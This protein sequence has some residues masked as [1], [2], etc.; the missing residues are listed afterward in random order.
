[1]RRQRAILLLSL[2][3]AG[4]CTAYST[5]NPPAPV[6]CSVTAAYDFDPMA[7]PVGNFYGSGD[8]TVGSI[9]T[10]MGLPDA[11]AICG[12]MS[13]L[14]IQASH[15]NDWGCLV[16]FYGVGPRNESAY[17]GVSFWARSPGATNKSFTLAID[18]AN[19]YGTTPDAGTFC[20]NY[21]PDGGMA[22][23]PSG[24]VYDPATNMP[25]S[26][27]STMAPPPNACGNSYVMVM[28]V[29]AD[30]QFYTVPFT[31]F[32]QAATPNRVPN[33]DLMQTGSV[34]GSALLSN[35]L[36]NIVFRM[37]R[38]AVTDLW[39]GNLG[40]YRH[41]VPGTGSDGGVDSP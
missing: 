19:T 33:A 13:G 17:E 5:L 39:I 16:G 15:N 37:P 29:T 12:V 25:I 21:Y 10:P 6:D 26:G 18:D 36:W 24:T 32:H 27:V 20:T 1:M 7:F 28:T 35:S 34:P 3:A 23:N 22:I 38:E 4:G 40:F 8:M 14:E 41:K 9:I 30:W 11:G 2:G 31:Q